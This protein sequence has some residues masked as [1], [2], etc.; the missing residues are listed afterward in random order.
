MLISKRTDRGGGSPDVLWE[1][2]GVKSQA[3]SVVPE[4]ARLTS[5]CSSISQK[6]PKGLLTE[7]YLPRDTFSFLVYTRR[8]SLP[9][10]VAA[11]VFCLQIAIFSLVSVDVIDLSSAGNP[12]N[13][14]PGVE[15]TVRATEVLAII[16]AILTQDDVKKVIHILRDGYDEDSFHDAFGHEA[17]RSKWALSIVLRGLQGLLGLFVTFMLIMQSNTVLDL[18]LNFS[19][20]EFV[21]L[22]DDVAFSM[23]SEGYL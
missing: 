17:S 7:R 22:L 12:L 4:F 3:K 2:A 8:L 16:V 21:S 14:P 10:L 15:A 18:L 5:Q 6:L 19:A 23:L 9:S 1:D 11:L 20:M 13:F